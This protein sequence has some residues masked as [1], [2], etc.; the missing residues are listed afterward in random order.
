MVLHELW[1]VVEV[2]V[3][4]VDNS[5]PDNPTTVH[6]E[7]LEPPKE[8]LAR[9]K[10]AVTE[11]AEVVVVVDKMVVLVDQCVA[12]TMVHFPVKMAIVWHPEAVLYPAVHMAVEAV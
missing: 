10:A 12:A 8:R 5:P 7:P 9:A 11:L 3:E 1:Q 4:V 2:V 6:Q